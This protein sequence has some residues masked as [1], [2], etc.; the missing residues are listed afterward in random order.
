ML[1]TDY[2]EKVKSFYT[3]FPRTIWLLFSIQRFSTCR[4]KSRFQG[5]RS[6]SQ[7]PLLRRRWPTL[8]TMRFLCCIL[9]PKPRHYWFWYGGEPL[10]GDDPKFKSRPE[11]RYITGYFKKDPKKVKKLIRKETNT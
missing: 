7:S 1:N 3:C 4:A 5:H 6:T 10:Q 11:H 2:I 8:W 9:V